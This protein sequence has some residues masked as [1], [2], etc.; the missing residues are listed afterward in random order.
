MSCPLHSSCTLLNLPNICFGSILR[1]HVCHRFTVLTIRPSS[2][3]RPFLYC[4]LHC[5]TFLKRNGYCM[6]ANRCSM[7]VG[8]SGR[9]GPICA[10]FCA[11]VI[12]AYTHV[13]SRPPSGLATGTHTS[14]TTISIPSVEHPLPLCPKSLRIVSRF[15]FFAIS[16][17][18]VPAIVIPRA[19]AASKP[20]SRHKYG[21]LPFACV[22]LNST[23]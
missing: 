4:T 10:T 16:G 17:S 7:V 12:V 11:G 13:V 5:Y 14:S 6:P 1:V 22:F 8:T 2:H 3:R 9:S 20:S 19:E 23:A 18:G 21:R 15:S